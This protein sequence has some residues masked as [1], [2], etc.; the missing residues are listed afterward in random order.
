[1]FANVL[2]RWI[3]RP[4][5][6]AARRKRARLNRRRSSFAFAGRP[7]HLEARSLLASLGGLV[8]EDHN[9][10]GVRN[11]GEAGLAGVTVYLDQ[12]RN[13]ALDAGETFTTTGA[14]GT[15]AFNNLAA[16]TYTVREVVPTGFAQTGPFPN[17]FYL[18][19]TRAAGGA[20]R[21]LVRTDAVTGRVTVVGS[22]GI[23]R[24]LN[25]LVRTNDGSLFAVAGENTGSDA[26]Y[27]VN[28][29]TGAATLIG[30]TGLEIAFG[31]AYD[32]ATDTIFGIGQVAPGLRGLV[33]YD[34][35]MGRATAVS[36]FSAGQP[37]S[38][39]G[40]A[41]DTV[42][43]RVLA[44]NF[45]DGQIYG[46]NP[47]TGERTT[48]AKIAAGIS[49]NLAFAEGQ[50]VMKRDFSGLFNEFIAIN[51]DTG[52]I[53]SL[54]FAS[55]GVVYESLELVDLPDFAH[56][57][58]V[59]PTQN[60]AGLDFGNLRVNS[61]PTA[62][63]GGPYTIREGDGLTL[64]ASGS[65]P[66]GDALGYTWD[67]NGDGQFGDAS[68]AAVSLSWSDLVAAG[69]GDDG[70]HQISVRVSDGLFSVD[71]SATLVIENVS[72]AI[73]SVS[74]TAASVGD[75]RPGQTVSVSAA[76]ADLGLLDVHT[77]TIDW[78]DGQQSSATISGGTVSGS[79]VYRQG[80]VYQVT[81]SVADDDGGAD[82]QT[83]TAYVT[84]ARLANGALQVV[85]T[86][87]ADSVVVT[88]QGRNSLL[89]RGG[90]LPR[91]GMTFDR[92]QTIS[93]EAYL[94]AGND[95]FTA[96]RNLTQPLLVVGGAGADTITAGRGRSVL[97]GGAGADSLT[98][99][100]NEDILIAGST[101]FD[102]N[103]VALRGILAEWTSARSLK[104]RVANLYDGSGAG[105]PANGDNFLVAGG[106]VS[107]DSH[108]DILNGG[109]RSR[110]W[111]F[112]D[113]RR[114]R[115]RG[116]VRDDLFAGDLDELLGR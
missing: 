91:R 97:I 50:L 1:M 103:V 83:V 116:N 65:D 99:G 112:H 82:T 24:N 46:Y 16:G 35:A 75:A 88:P 113:P 64:Q 109:G 69:I 79:H 90:F 105:S 89:V 18:S 26:F 3:W 20:P 41:F 4:S 85:G 59:G 96:H 100:S 72:P 56:T 39:N 71:A 66:D 34:R 92:G 12:N 57:V 17:D 33:T 32:P 93:I 51:P 74:T 55:V 40:M 86:A 8:F 60:V 19:T 14:T 2:S 110:D 36:T 61:P 68:G 5:G 11:S 27:S 37:S 101:A 7:E 15:Y 76:F 23:S 28:P 104:D 44:Y 87:R 30:N 62:S 38:T 67:L 70:T 48:L 77:A 111:L 31:L 95:R 81:L 80:G 102:D 78:G 25:G 22:L 9:G 10:N 94:G 114:D 29:V 73:E 98:G 107:N 6:A 53:T 108:R 43:N 106:T 13:G 47:A 84:G 45:D 49:A 52:Q 21:Q 115:L 42:R 58:D 54:F 63:A